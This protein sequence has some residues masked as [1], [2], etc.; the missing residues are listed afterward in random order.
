MEKIYL[1]ETD[2]VMYSLIFY[3]DKN[4]K[5]VD[6]EEEAVRAVIYEYNN[7]NEIVKTNFVILKEDNKIYENEDTAD[8]TEVINQIK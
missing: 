7:K 6:N 2:G 4:D 8:L 5:S 1:N 3:Y